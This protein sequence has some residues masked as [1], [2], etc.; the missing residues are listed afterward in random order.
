MFQV[1]NFHKLLSCLHASI[2][3]SQLESKF[4]QKQ[5]CLVCLFSN[6]TTI[7]SILLKVKEESEKADLNSTYKNKDHGTWSPSLHGK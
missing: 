5:N 1:I 6:P 7:L 3:P 4:I 2:L